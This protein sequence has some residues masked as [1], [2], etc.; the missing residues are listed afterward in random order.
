MVHIK[1]DDKWIEERELGWKKQVRREYNDGNDDPESNS[2]Y[3]LVRSYDKKRIE[4]FN[5]ITY[6]IICIEVKEHS[7]KIVWMMENS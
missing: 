6:K 4:Y 5:E 1:Q 7:I 2:M 3:S